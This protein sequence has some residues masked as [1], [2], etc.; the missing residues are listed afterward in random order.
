MQ[1]ILMI[2][3]GRLARHL[4]YWNSLLEKPNRLLVW[5][6]KENTI[7]QLQTD[8]KRS[9]LVWLAISDSAL[10][11]FFEQHFL[12]FNHP[13]VHFSGALHDER[14]QS[15]HPFM[16]FPLELMDPKVY[17]RI[18]FALTGPTQFNK[19]MP[20]FKNSFSTI[21]PSQKSLYH[22]LCVV[23]GNFPQVLWHET[24]PEFAKL[25]IPN[26]AFENYLQQITTNFL[27]LKKNA[28]TGPLIRN[29]V[30][31]IQK[32]KQALQ[33]SKLKKIYDTFVEVF[34]K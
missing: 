4:I 34:T 5:N 2:G 8:L 17:Q 21:D 20:G 18:H 29:D 11:S 7:E 22:S 24:E 3:S 14:L 26:E 16:S 15:A 25:N 13:I 33:F 19:C 12:N 10:V 1:T 27:K 32:N 6:R 28:L 31:T 23:A 30:L 9:N